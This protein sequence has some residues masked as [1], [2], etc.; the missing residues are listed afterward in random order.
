MK[1]R[2]KYENSLLTVRFIGEHLNT[3][4]ASIYDLG[5]SL[6][7]I[8]RLI[9]KAFLAK[10]NRIAKGGF[11]DKSERERLALQIGE[12][13]RNSDAFALISVLTDA[14]IQSYLIDVIKYMINGLYGYSVKDV[15]DRIRGERDINKQF[16]IGSIHADVVNLV[17]RV[18]ASGG[19]EAIS[20]GSPALNRDSVISFSE[21]NKDYINS[22]KNEIYY[23]E[24]QNITG[25]VYRMYAISQIV[26]I[27]VSGSPNISIHLNED[28]F[29]SIR[30]CED[31]A[32]LVRF[33][34]R[35]IYKF[36]ILTKD[37]TEFEAE[38]IEILEDVDY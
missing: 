31:K 24:L 13:K 32:P 11:P 7:A 35:P 27:R 15:L 2:E 20:I 1:K 29:N 36:G 34:G 21:E 22:L 16:Y 6:V 9:H 18:D 33:R 14:T 38:R 25:K 26:T 12:R 19:V 23:G 28:D 30:Y 37:V 8:Q 10:E 4:G 5:T 17:G 3:R